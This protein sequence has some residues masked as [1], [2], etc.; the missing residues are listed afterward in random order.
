VCYRLW[1]VLQLQL[2]V[3]VGNVSRNKLVS[4]NS[5]WFYADTA[6]T[7]NRRHVAHYGD[8]FHDKRAPHWNSSINPDPVFMPGQGLG[9][10]V[11]G[12]PNFS[13]SG[14]AFQIE[15]LGG[16]KS[17]AAGLCVHHSAVDLNN[18]NHRRKRQVLVC[19]MSYRYEYGCPPQCC[20][21]TR[22]IT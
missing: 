22:T 12:S 3:A 8:G 21:H 15:V 16:K 10:G 5:E 11:S 19:K 1:E 6:N 13:V 18:E 20:M 17:P 14:L 4:L 2:H 9:K 7:M